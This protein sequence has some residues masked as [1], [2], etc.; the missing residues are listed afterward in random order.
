M[1]KKY[2]QPSYILADFHKQKYNL[3]FLNKY[4][5][6]SSK[7]TLKAATVSIGLSELLL[8]DFKL[9]ATIFSSIMWTRST[10]RGA[11]GVPHLQ[12]CQNLKSGPQLTPLEILASES[13]S[14]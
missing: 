5:A 9:D 14:L 1:G 2:S 6:L 3:Y 8:H 12:Q 10:Y 13:L 4:L 7:P 11:V